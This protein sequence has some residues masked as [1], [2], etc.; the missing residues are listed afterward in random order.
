MRDLNKK[1]FLN[2]GKSFAIFSALVCFFLLIVVYSIMLRH[3]IAA[4]KERYGYIAKNE[5]EHIVTTI[6]CVMARTSTLKAMVQDHKGDTSFFASAAEDV[7]DAVIEETGVSLKNLAIAPDG[8]VSDV[9]PLAGNE[10]LIGFDFLDTSRPGNFEAKEAYEQGSTILTNP[11]ELIQGGVGMGGRA[12][13]ILRDGNTKKLWGLVTVTIDFDNLIDVLKLDNLKGM[14]VDYTLSF[15]DADDTFHV[16]HAVGKPNHDM[17]KTQF[18]VRNLTWQL[19]MAPEKGWISLWRVFLAVLLILIISGFTGVFAN[20]MFQLHESNAML[21]RISNTDGLTGCLN[22]RAYEEAVSELSNKPVD[23]DFVYVLA[24]VNGLKHV[25]DTLGHL[26]G[27]ELITGVAMCMKE[28][29]G[30]YGSVY[31]IGGDEFA[32]MI[33]ADEDTLAGIRDRIRAFMDD[34]EGQ[35]VKGLSV[36]FGYALSREF[37]EVTVETLIK[38][39]DEGMYAEKQEYYQQQGFADRGDVTIVQSHGGNFR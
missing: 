10:S 3:D 30:T 36:S 37:P 17:V 20:T 19:E 29:F 5:A 32:A 38:V 23:C 18:K 25:N 33:Y 26:S 31:R 16:M 28:S 2:N 1:I 22:R 15:R 24:D 34:W 12:P 27:D 14:G 6:D 21:L 4:E 7:Y 11:F 9:Y 39:A 35:S 13:V 8:I